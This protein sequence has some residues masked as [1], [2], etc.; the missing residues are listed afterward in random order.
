[1]IAPRDCIDQHGTE[2]AA[3]RRPFQPI[4]SLRG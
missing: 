4:P 2:K 3:T 1:M